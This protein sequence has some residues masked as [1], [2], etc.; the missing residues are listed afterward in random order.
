MTVTLRDVASAAGVHPGTASKALN[1]ATRDRV[2]P[3]TVQR[4]LAAAKRLG[5]QPNTF[6]RGLRTNRSYAIGV[7]LPD[8]TNPLF[9]PIVRGA[10]Q[11]L[12]AAGFLALIADT[13]ND[14]M[15]EERIMT[16]LRS[17]NADGYLVATARR[18][19]PLLAQAAADGL[20]IVLV[21]RT[22]E[23]ADVPAV[24]GDETSGVTA[25]V[26]HLVELGHRHIGHVAGPQ[27]LSTGYARCQAFLGALRR[28]GLTDADCPV[29]FATALTEAAGVAAARSLLRRPSR[30]TAIV[31]GNDLIALGCLD[32]L[33]ELG[34]RCPADVSLVGFNDMPLLDRLTPPLTTVRLP[35]QAIGEE[36]ARL[37]LE[38]IA[39]PDRAPK[40]LLLPC[41]LIVRGSTSSP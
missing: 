19:H 4:V 1:E 6:A 37:L 7:V 23:S 27:E 21:N 11:A 24:L 12:A 9:P 13:D 40:R 34:L 35:Q 16:A 33:G 28:F 38:R 22:T 26:E 39:E 36:A 31:A 15:V 17:R 3:G 8:L 14:P 41:P 2:A 18:D 30:P 32:V 20:P 10:E 5:Y 25:A 29:T